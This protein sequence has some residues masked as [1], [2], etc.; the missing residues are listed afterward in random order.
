M[1]REKG[2]LPKAYLRI[3]PHLASTHENAGEFVRLLEA[4]YEQPRRG[5][6][7]NLAVLRAAAGRGIA[8]RAVGRR[9]VVT[10]G[11]LA[12]CLDDKGSPREFCSGD[13]PH[14]YLNAWDEWQEGDVTVGERVARIRARKA[15]RSNGDDTPK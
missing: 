12:D 2:V 15:R 9:D 13:L 11:V 7:K 6:F 10:H 1:T 4:A 3:D 5:R 8:D 14:L